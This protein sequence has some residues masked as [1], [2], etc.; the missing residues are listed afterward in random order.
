MLKKNTLLLLT[1]LSLTFAMPASGDDLTDA[2]TY[3]ET[4]IARSYA[5]LTQPELSEKQRYTHALALLEEHLSFPAIGRLSVGHHWRDMSSEQQ[6][7]YLGLFERWIK[8]SIAQRMISLKTPT[9][10]NISITGERQNKKTLIISTK[11][12]TDGE[13]IL[14]VWH[15]RK[16]KSG[17]KIIDLDIEGISMVQTQRAEFSAIIAA[18][19]V[20]GFLETLKAML[21]NIEKWNPNA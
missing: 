17:M 2:R 20:S 5:L 21:E 10:S 15:L 3:V 11:V 13:N 1:F 7:E 19:G 12:T 8:T 4:N 18:K 6:S 9:S 16:L 14:L